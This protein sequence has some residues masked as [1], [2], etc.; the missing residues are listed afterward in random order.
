MIV[1]ASTTVDLDQGWPSSSPVLVVDVRDGCPPP[2]A[3]SPA[4]LVC[5]TSIKGIAHGS[6]TL[7]AGRL[8][9]ARQGLA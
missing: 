9:T 6:A 4:P 2:I 3:G 1:F 5:L 7:L 8:P